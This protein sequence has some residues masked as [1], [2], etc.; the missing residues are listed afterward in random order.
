MNLY[1]FYLGGKAENANIEVH[2]V[3]FLASE[4]WSKETDKIK[5]KWFG[6]CSSVHIDAIAVI[7]GNKETIIKIDCP[8]KGLDYKLFFINFGGSQQGVFSEFHENGFFIAHNKSEAI[9]QA[10][11]VLCTKFDDVHLDNLLE[12]GSLIENKLSFAEGKGTVK[13]TTC[14]KKI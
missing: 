9:F 7:S 8:E 14:Y 2:D 3:V 12:V 1:A 13:I 11:E 6:D 5:A 10:K 4:N